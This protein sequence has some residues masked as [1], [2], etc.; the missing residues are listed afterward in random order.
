MH[1]GSDSTKFKLEAM[2]FP[3]SLKQARADF[4]NN[5]LPEDILLPDNKKVHF[6]NKF[7]YLGSI[8][9]PLLNENSEMEAR[10]KK[11]SQ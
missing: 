8:I 5:H 1:L 9:T 4:A 2:Y 11:P 7:K 6:T 3:P 10:I